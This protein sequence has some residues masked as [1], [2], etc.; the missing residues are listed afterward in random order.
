MFH[1]W[2]KFILK[3]RQFIPTTCKMFTVEQWSVVPRRQNVCLKR[4]IF[5]KPSLPKE[6]TFEF[7]FLAYRW[8]DPFPCIYFKFINQTKIKKKICMHSNIQNSN[9]KAPYIRTR[10]TTRIGQMGMNCQIWQTY[11]APNYFKRKGEQTCVPF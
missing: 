2:G 1:K 3:L 11:L 5:F 4:G 10:I 9:L 8:N 7:L 6:L